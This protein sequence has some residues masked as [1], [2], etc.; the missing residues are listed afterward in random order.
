MFIWFFLI[1]EFY[2]RLPLAEIP[3]SVLSKTK[4][5]S[6]V[7]RTM[8]DNPLAGRDIGVGEDVR[9]GHWFT[10]RQIVRWND[11]GHAHAK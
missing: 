4:S 6:G 10:R 8:G 1:V 3:R 2:E 7:W 11:K 5:R 9:N